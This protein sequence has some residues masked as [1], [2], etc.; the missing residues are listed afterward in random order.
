VRSYLIE[1][2]RKSDPLRPFQAK[3]V[4]GA[5]CGAIDPDGHYWSWPRF[6]GIGKVLGRIS[7]Y[8]HEHGR[9]LLSVLV[10]HAGSLQA[11]DGF[12]G[13]GRGLG[14]EIQPGQERAFWRSQLEEVVRYWTSHAAGTETLT[15]TQRALALLTT[16]GQ[17]LQEVR[18]L[19]GAA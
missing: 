13:L 10:V 15:P 7:T 17:D 2:V 3:I 11:G 18:R 1:R 14:F 6:R 16:I 12:A 5:L 19:L 9:P 8:E 4:Y